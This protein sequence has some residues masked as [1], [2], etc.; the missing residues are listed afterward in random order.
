M[1]EEDDPRSAPLAE[2]GRRFLL[3]PDATFLNH[4][5]YGAC[6]APVFETYQR[7]QRELEAE[8]VEFLGRRIRSLLADARAPLAAYLGAGQ[9]DLVFVPN[10]THGVNIVARSLQKLLR[11]GDEVLGTDHE[12]GAVERTWRFVTEQVGAIYRPQPMSLPMRDQTEMVGRIWAGVTERTRILVLSHITSPTALILPVRELIRRARE[13][14]IIT[15]VDGA[16]APGQIPL[17]LDDLGA[18]FYAGN[19]HKMAL[20]RKRR[21]IEPLAQPTLER[22]RVGVT[23]APHIQLGDQG[24]QGTALVIEIGA[25]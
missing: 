7:W 25:L 6:P 15:V 13:R 2:A 17:A 23:L 19:C 12:Y 21:G 11:E 9:D 4:G 8:P 16:H 14:G 22:H 1:P 18:D 20:D 3:R 10:A 24:E 5:S